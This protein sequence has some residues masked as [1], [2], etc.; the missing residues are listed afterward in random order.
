MPALGRPLGG[1]N[2][3]Q[4]IKKHKELTRSPKIVDGKKHGR[5][6]K[7][8]FLRLLMHQLNNQDPLKPIDQNKMAADLAQ[9]SQLEQMTNMNK[10]LEKSLENNIIKKKFF[11]ASFLGKK[12]ITDGASIK[13]RGE[14]EQP[15]VSFRISKA[16]AKGLV[17]IY[18][19]NKQMIAQLNLQAK[20]PGIHTIPWNGK[21]LDGMDAGKGIYTF[22]VKAW[23]QL[24]NEIIAETR[25]EGVVT[26]VSFDE[27]GGSIIIVDGKKVYLR[28]VKTFSF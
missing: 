8:G 15:A 4:G 27:H 16:M 12:V 7:D 26:G 3:Y 17:Q 6:E 14:G 18:D 25:A 22:Q 13:Y 10:N 21:Q 11:A 9:F 20:P 24:N 5:L 19:K 1:D 28:D 2:P 23:D